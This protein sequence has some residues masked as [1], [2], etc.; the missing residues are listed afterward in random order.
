MK[1]REKATK[2][3][4]T[5][6]M[7]INLKEGNL[8]LAK[9]IMEQNQIRHLPVVSGDKL[10]GIISLT[11]I[12]R[13]SYGANYGQEEAV[14]K[15]IFDVLSLANVMVHHP[16]TISPDTT[17][18]EAA[19]ILGREE[20]HALPVTEGDKLVGIMTSTDLIKYLLEQY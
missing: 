4:S 11:D 2:I 16:T 17:I 12:H 18:K 14:D 9:D 7:T 8:A 5:K 6:L 15:A 1:K 10:L 3:M 13:I 20:F 19:E